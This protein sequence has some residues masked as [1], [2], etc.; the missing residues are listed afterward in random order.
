MESVQVEIF[1]QTYS[2][3][4][5]NDREYIQELAMFVDGRMKEIQKSTGTSDVY[6]IAI[7]TALNITDELH[8]LRSQHDGLKKATSS[9]LDRLM[10]I[11]DGVE[12]K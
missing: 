2:I 11:T 3:K 6:R 8:R 9:S 4:V 10:E 12:R 5:A 1:G 7:L